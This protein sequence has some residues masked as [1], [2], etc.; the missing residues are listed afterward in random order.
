[1]L[2][3]GEVIPFANPGIKAMIWQFLRCEFVISHEDRLLPLTPV[4]LVLAILSVSHI[5]LVCFWCGL[6][7]S[8]GTTGMQLFVALETFQCY[9]FQRGSSSKSFSS[10]QYRP[11]F[12]ALVQELSDPNRSTA[13]QCKLRQTLGSFGCALLPL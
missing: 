9:G 13:D 11:H 6:L 3:Q 1:M 4:T 10:S 7:T 8:P 12:V 2:H 5:A